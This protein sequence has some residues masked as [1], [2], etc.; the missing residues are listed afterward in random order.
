MRKFKTP[1]LLLLLLASLL[2]AVYPA[3][4]CWYLERHHSQIRTEYTEDL[5][6]ANDAEVAAA[7]AAAAAYNDK[8]ASGEYQVLDYEKNGYFELLDLTGNGIMGFLEIP[9][10]DLNLTVY[11]GTSDHVLRKGVGHMEQSSLP[12]GGIGTHAVLSAHTGSTDQRLFT[13]LELLRLGDLFYI[14]VLGNKMAYR[15]D[16]IVT[17]VP[18]DVSDVQIRQ[19]EDLVTLLTCTPYGINSHR[20]LVRGRRIDLQEAQQLEPDTGDSPLPPTQSIWMRHYIKGI[21]CGLLA[22]AVLVAGML[23]ARRSRMRRKRE[24]G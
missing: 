1:L 17:A 7:Y 14:T 3:V 8:L 20:L 24:Q 4:S 11:H 2:A 5:Q 16:Q 22:A 10:L 23:L 19:G 18:E 6:S 9:R 12:V 21:V 15:V 13:D